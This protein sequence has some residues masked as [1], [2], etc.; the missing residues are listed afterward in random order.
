MVDLLEAARAQQDVGR[1]GGAPG[2]EHDSSMTWSAWQGPS[3]SGTIGMMSNMPIRGPIGSGTGPILADDQ[4][5]AMLGDWSA[6]GH[7]GLA[8]RLAQAIRAAISSGIVSGGARLPAE[9]HLA[10]LLSVSRSTITSALDELRSE[11]LLMSR[12]GSGTE[13][14]GSMASTS[15]GDRVGG[16]FINRGTGIDLAAIVPTE[17]HHLPALTLRTEDLIA[18]QGQLAPHGLPTLR[19]ALAQRH[20]AAGRFT[21]REQI[22][23]THGAHHAIALVVDALVRPGAAVVIE[24]PAY[25]GI[26][27]LVD[28]RRGRGVAL[29][30]QAGGPDPEELRRLLRDERP[31]LVYLQTGV[32]NPT[33]QLTGPARRRA[34]AQVL[35]E[36]GDTVLLADN[37]LADLAF[38]GRPSLSF[39]NLCRVVPVVTVESVSKVAWAGLRLG[40]LRAT[41]SVGER[42]ARVRVANDL[43]ASVPS[44]LL[45]HQLLDTY[46]DVADRRR[47][48]L[49]TAVSAAVERMRADLPEWEV[50]AP[51]GS[52]A[53]WPK[54]PIDDAA[55]FVAL[56]RRH[57]VHV[58]PGGAHVV[59]GGRDPHLRFCVD[60]PI[61]HVDEGIGRLITA[62][63][64]LSSRSAR[65]IA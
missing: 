60:R 8:R 61:A 56:A 44:Q 29:T 21:E 64:D 28:H 32:H 9:R 25:P 12:Q 50:V 27:D 57:G 42:I 35:D 10:A 3:Q 45:V 24:D 48:Q 31:A 43:G 63:H 65:S 30:L 4:L 52:S 14:A 6:S 55:P 7:G 19:D 11:G 26:L 58:T 1:T 22:Q 34:L 20:T 13:V 17:G 51:V 40:W 5:I 33:G 62:W 46:D 23:V 38:D 49:A 47:A 15:T 18:A 59:G 36:F 54:L 53:I 39:E 37:T 2:G 16:H 41:G